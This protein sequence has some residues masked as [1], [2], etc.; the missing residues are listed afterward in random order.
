MEEGLR[1]IMDWKW[2]EGKGSG[3]W[4]GEDEGWVEEEGAGGRWEKEER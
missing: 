1:S 2:F 3:G 4:G